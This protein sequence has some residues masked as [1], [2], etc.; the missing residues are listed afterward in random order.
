MKYIKDDITGSFYSLENA[1]LIQHPQNID[2]SMD[3]ST[4]SVELD[5]LIY[6]MHQLVDGKE[7]DIYKHLSGIKAKLELDIDT[8]D[9]VE[10]II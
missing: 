2:G 7:V 10:S 8:V 9:M 5:E 3:S 4:A 6:E 1:E